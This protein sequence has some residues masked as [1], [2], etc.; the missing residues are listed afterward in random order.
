MCTLPMSHV[1]VMQLDLRWYQYSAIVET[2]KLT[3][4]QAGPDSEFEF[5]LGSHFELD[6]WV[7]L[8]H[9]HDQ[10]TDHDVP[11]AG[12]D[13]GLSSADPDDPGLDDQG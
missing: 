7:E 13:Y 1:H 4:T 9:Q 12:E 10:S 6:D 2:T 5:E 3:R 11:S 8:D